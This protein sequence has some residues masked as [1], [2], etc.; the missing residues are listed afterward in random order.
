LTIAYV[1]TLPSVVA[2]I[3]YNRGVELIGANRAGAFIHLVPLFGA[4]LAIWLLDERL[5]LFHLGA[6]A[7]ILAGV[8]LASRPR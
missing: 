6:F 3:F 7:L 4:L 2:Q 1:S 5:H 8:T